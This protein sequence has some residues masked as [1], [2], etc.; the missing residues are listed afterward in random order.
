M[1]T[2]EVQW[3]GAYRHIIVGRDHRMEKQTGCIGF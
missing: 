2:F 1:N 3:T